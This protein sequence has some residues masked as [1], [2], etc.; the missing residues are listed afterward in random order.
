MKEQLSKLHFSTFGESH[1]ENDIKLDD[2]SAPNRPTLV[3]EIYNMGVDWTGPSSNNRSVIGDLCAYWIEKNRLS[4]Q[5]YKRGLT[6][7]LNTLV[8]LVIDVP[9]V[10]EYTAAMIGKLAIDLSH[11]I[12]N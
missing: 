3:Q 4:K 2:I 6:E 10:Y 7:F 5:D 1:L 8:D 9:K 12:T 11:N